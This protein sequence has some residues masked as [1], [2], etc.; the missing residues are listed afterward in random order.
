LT[1]VGAHGDNEVVADRYKVTELE[2]VYQ[3]LDDSLVV[4]A[5]VAKKIRNC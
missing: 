5:V 2:Q 3:K 1:D 4:E